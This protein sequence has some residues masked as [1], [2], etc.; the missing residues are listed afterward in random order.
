MKRRKL[1]R[2]LSILG[3]VLFVAGY[4]VYRLGSERRHEVDAEVPTSPSP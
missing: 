3:L 4:T 1:A 2:T